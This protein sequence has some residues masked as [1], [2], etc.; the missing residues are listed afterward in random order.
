[1]NTAMTAMAQSQI[2]AAISQATAVAGINHDGLRGEL[3]EIISRQLLEPLLPPGWEIGSG[4]I[5]SAFNNHSPQT[6]LVIYDRSIVPSLLV[7]KHHGLYPVEAALAAIEVKST[8]TATELR[9]ADEKARKIRKLPFSAGSSPWAVLPIVFAFGSDL[10]AGGKDEVTRYVEQ[11]GND[12]EGLLQICV[13]G[14]G[15]WCYSDYKW[16]RRHIDGKHGEVLA[17]L[18]ALFGRLPEFR[19]SRTTPDLRSYFTL[20]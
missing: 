10:S 15:H 6:D 7:G 3:R 14:R 4:E 19:K 2:E 8:L 16:H 9:D 18:A 13:V 1:M 5:I 17:F 20:P 11:C 12:G